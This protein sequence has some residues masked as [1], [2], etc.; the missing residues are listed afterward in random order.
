MNLNPKT[1]YVQ[2]D[3]IGRFST[4][5]L[6]KGTMCLYRKILPSKFRLFNPFL[7]DLAHC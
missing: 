4:V 7:N 5:L 1:V 2:L 3:F 6:S